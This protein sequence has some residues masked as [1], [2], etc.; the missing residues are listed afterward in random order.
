MPEGPSDEDPSEGSVEDPSSEPSEEPS[1]PS[2]G[3]YEQ[4]LADAKDAL[5]AKQAALAD[6][7]MVAYAEADT[8]LTK[9]LEKLLELSE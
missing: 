9:A 1:D 2:G 7:D 6:G 4:A 5:D 8:E 3:T